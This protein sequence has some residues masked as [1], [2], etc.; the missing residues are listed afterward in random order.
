MTAVFLGHLQPGVCVPPGC[1]EWR[2]DERFLM[3]QH[4]RTPR[5]VLPLGIRFPI[6]R[7]IDRLV[8][9]PTRLRSSYWSL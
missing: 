7:G 3:R 5:G 2:V 6:E 4:L 1:V 8:P 9:L